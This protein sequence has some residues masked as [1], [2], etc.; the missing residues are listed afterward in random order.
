MTRRTATTD[1]CAPPGKVGAGATFLLAGVARQLD[2]VDGKHFASDQALPVAQGENLSEE[3]GDFVTQAADESGNGGPVRGTV[4]GEGNESDVLTAGVFDSATADDAL[5]VGE[6]NNFEQSA[7]QVGASTGGVVAAAPVKAGQ[8]D[9][10]VDQVV[11]CVLEGTGHQLP[12]Q[13]HGNEPRTRVDHFVTR[14]IGLLL[15]FELESCH[16]IWF[17]AECRHAITFST[18]SLGFIPSESLTCESLSQSKFLDTSGCQKDLTNG[19]RVYCMS[20]KPVR[21]L[22]K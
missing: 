22:S 14:H 9:F 20:R 2:A 6:Q 8:I 12:L 4:A 11:Q 13:I 15:Y 19:Y 17:T 7:R 10:V 21:P 5:A 18:A 1:F 16:S 3:P